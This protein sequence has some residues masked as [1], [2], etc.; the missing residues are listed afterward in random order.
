MT[1]KQ[2]KKL[3]WN[4]EGSA[5]FEDENCP[6]CGVYLSPL[7]VGGNEAADDLLNPPYK[8]KPSDEEEQEIPASPYGQQQ[9]EE[10]IEEEPIRNEKEDHAENT[11]QAVLLPL[12]ILSTGFVFLLFSL[13]LLLFSQNDTL[14]LRWNAN[15]WFVYLAIGIALLFVS[16]KIL[17]S[18]E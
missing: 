2:K 3:C 12:V 13:A 8:L 18:K 14:T 10:E 6:Y 16:W 17:D 4:C 15:Y 7:S 11:V 1:I 5:S 9:E